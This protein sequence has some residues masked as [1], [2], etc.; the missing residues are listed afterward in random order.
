MPCPICPADGARD[1]VVPR[2]CGYLGLSPEASCLPDF[3]PK[4]LFLGAHIWDRGS[5]E[6][7]AG[8]VWMMGTGPCP[9]GLGLA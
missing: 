4:H 3:Q 6:A 9:S 2:A 8:T 1:R 7:G 5:L